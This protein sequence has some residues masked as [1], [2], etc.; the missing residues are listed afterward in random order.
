MTLRKEENPFT[1]GR[2]SLWLR[3]PL[4]Y[5]VYDIYYGG[6]EPILAL[7][8]AGVELDAADE[9]GD[10]ALHEAV[11][12]SKP[13]IYALLVQAGANQHK[14]K[15]SVAGD[16][17]ARFQVSAGGAWLRT[18]LRPVLSAC[19]LVTRCSEFVVLI[20]HWIISVLPS[21]RFLT[22]VAPTPK[23]YP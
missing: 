2:A 15:K 21:M 12:E 13:E 6:V 16:T 14:P 23:I 7:L 4:Q 20:H 3:P 11:Y 1:P 22:N 19:S 9:H 10:T 5:A 8:E 17:P 18:V